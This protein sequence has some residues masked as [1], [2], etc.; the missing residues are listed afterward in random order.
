[1]WVIAASCFR[2]FDCPAVSSRCVELSHT[3][4]SLTSTQYQSDSPSP[5]VHTNEACDT[6]SNNSKTKK[7][8]DDV[9]SEVVPT[10]NDVL[11]GRGAFINEHPGNRQF[12]TL[13]LERKIEFDRSSPADKRMISTKIV[14]L[15]KGMAHP[16]HLTIIFRVIQVRNCHQFTLPYLDLTPPGRFLKRASNALQEPILL[17]DGKYEL[18]P[19]GL[20]GPWEEVPDEQAYSKAMQVLRDL[21][22]KV[23]A[24]MV[25]EEE[26]APEETCKATVEV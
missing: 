2:C 6:S 13:A 17:S 26:R 15:T 3:F 16:N 8:D 25:S 7:D 10:D 4:L 19:R 1:M 14:E 20:E 18:P 22:T 5:N 11:L 21:K 24:P 9:D 12:R 23:P